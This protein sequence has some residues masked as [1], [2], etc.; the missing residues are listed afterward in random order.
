MKSNII[1][2]IAGV[3]DTQQLT[4][5]KD[6]GSTVAIPQGDPRLARIISEI[7]PVLAQGP[8]SVAEVDLQD[9]E[10]ASNPYKEIEDMIGVKFFRVLKSLAVKLL[11]DATK[12][13]MEPVAPIT[14][15]I[16]GKP[17]IIGDL[18]LAATLEH[19][20]PKVEKLIN[21]ASEII[22]HAKPSNHP[23]FHD[24][25]LDASGDTI[26]AVVGDQVMTDME[27]LKPQFSRAVAGNSPIG[28]QNFMTRI[29]AVAK[30]RNHS[31]EDLLKF[32]KRGD[33]PVA[34]DGSIVI[35]KVLQ[36]K[37]DKFVDCYTKRVTQQVGSYVCMDPKLVDHDR[38][39]ECSNGLNVARRAF[40]HGFSGD[41][42][43]LAKVNPEDV[44]AVPDYDANK[45][46]V[47]G[48]HILF[49][50]SSEDHA[51]LRRNEPF[52]D[53]AEAQLLLGRALAGDHPPAKE[54]VRITHHMGGGVVITPVIEGR[55]VEFIDAP[56][57]EVKPAEALADP[58]APTKLNAPAVSPK[59]V[60][61]EVTKAK[62]EAESRVAKAIRLYVAFKEAKS[63]QD[64]KTT[65]E[66]LMEHKKSTKLGWA[67]LGLD[68]TVA[69]QLLK[70]LT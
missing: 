17:Q 35:Y 50:L 15:Q 48:Y 33:L 40:I 39:N 66:T 22:A 28:M 69:D 19:P 67:A 16:I 57:V 5:Y 3:V 37:G 12:E 47:C 54:I 9:G 51:K 65:A 34:D 56:K 18:N 42:C 41:V 49:Q 59:A 23:E 45:M 7:T 55:K 21:A 58:E 52:T 31:V 29:A 36:S 63:K 10:D 44:I 30:D 46:R 2:V 24:R 38:R 14:P 27:N 70:V 53:N 6:D 61:K 8:G 4:L 20:T 43:V 1:K 11:Q 64:K 60:Q 13:V 68:P 25:D 62:V 32:M 26:V